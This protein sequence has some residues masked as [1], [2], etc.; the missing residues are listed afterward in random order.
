MIRIAALVLS[1]GALVASSAGGMQT[2]WPY[3]TCNDAT[4][5]IFNGHQCVPLVVPIPDGITILSP[6]VDAANQKSD[7]C[8]DETPLDSLGD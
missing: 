3:E 8:P 5:W 7:N 4:G 2:S 6:S 1:A